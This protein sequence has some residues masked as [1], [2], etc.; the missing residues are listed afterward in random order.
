MH[1]KLFL[2]SQNYEQTKLFVAICSHCDRNETSF[3][4]RFHGLMDSFH[5]LKCN[6]KILINQANQ[7]PFI[8]IISVLSKKLENVNSSFKYRETRD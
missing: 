2:Q 8:I 5:V 3:W 6:V 4:A 1:V 7:N